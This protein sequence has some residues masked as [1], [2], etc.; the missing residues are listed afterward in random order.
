MCISREC[1]SALPCKYLWYYLS[2]TSIGLMCTFFNMLQQLFPPGPAS[3]HLFKLIPK[4]WDLL[5][6]LS[7]C[8]L[9]LLSH[10][11]NLNYTCLCFC[12]W[13]MI[14]WFPGSPLLHFSQFVGHLE[15]FYYYCDSMVATCFTA[16]SLHC[17][18]IILICISNHSSALLYCVGCRANYVNWSFSKKC[19]ASHSNS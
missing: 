19:L 2:L 11:L 12:T 13:N 1:V 6:S 8:F 9:T 15:S 16:E 3:A 7:Y 5:H 4:C 10:A 17:V 18:K 14:G